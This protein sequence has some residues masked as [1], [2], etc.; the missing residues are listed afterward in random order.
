T[1]NP[2][3]IS[4]GIRP[5]RIEASEVVR[6]AIEQLKDTAHRERRGAQFVTALRS[7]VGRLQSNPN[8]FGERLFSLPA[9][10]LETRCAV[11]PPI[12]LDFAVSE[13]RRVVYLRTIKLLG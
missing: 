7:I 2:D 9:M 8:R 12:Y 10:R 5:F 11:V 1:M 4:N 13:E 6:S 3:P